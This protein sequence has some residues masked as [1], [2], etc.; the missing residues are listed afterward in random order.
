MKPEP[1]LVVRMD[2]DRA[3]DKKPGT[4][5]LGTQTIGQAAW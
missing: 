4:G 3:P 5:S 2:C 1:L